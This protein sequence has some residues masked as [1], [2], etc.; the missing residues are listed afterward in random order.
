MP[1]VEE[2]VSLVVDGNVLRGWQEVSVSRSMQKAAI[3]F[4]LTATNPTWSAEAKALRHGKEIE[5]RTSLASGPFQPG[6]GDLLCKGYVDAYSAK[7]GSESKTIRVSGRSKAADAI[8]CPPV[9][10][11]TGRVEKKTLDQ[12]AKEF[13]EFGIEWRTDQKL[14][15]IPKV[16]R[17]PDEP[18]FATI[19]REAR[20]LGMMLAAQPD[21][22]V[23]ITR[24]GTKRHAGAIVMGE[25][26]V[27]EMDVQ[28]NLSAK[29]SPVV[30]RGQR[31]TG[32]GGEN[33]RQQIE[34]VDQSVGRHR[35]L[36]ILLEGDAPEKE[37]KKR[38]KWERLRAAGFGVNVSAELST[39][40]DE[41][42][43]I[44][45]PGRLLA[46]VCAEEDVDQDLTL[47]TVTLKQN[48]GDGTVASLALVD[49]RAHGGK[50]AKG[51][52]G[53]DKAYD[54]GDGIDDE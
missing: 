25:P 23:M 17:R 39:W 9:K 19:E 6:G 29:R 13:D 1:F 12:V 50:K 18:L 48:L 35:P 41:G 38:G 31:A 52:K 37:L 20:R 46:T 24:A 43:L 2:I 22:S 45:D 36:V 16:Q 10:H 26:P 4:S 30:V 15:P 44:W 53:S 42:G 7:Y 49:P 3:S 51:G 8:D 21:G 40:R 47:S 33:L 34:E 5:I 32:T 28:I 11:K 14:D 27:Q 54:P